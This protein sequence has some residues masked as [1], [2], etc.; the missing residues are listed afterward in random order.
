M[1]RGLFESFSAKVR[2]FV[3]VTLLCGKKEVVCVIQQS[4]NSEKIKK[5]QQ[6]ATVFAAG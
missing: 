1:G 5:G 2:L 3:Q 6:T 4:K